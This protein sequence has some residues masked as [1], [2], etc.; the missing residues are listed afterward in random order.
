MHT[1][2]E[3][4]KT[5]ERQATVGILT[6]ER[7]DVWAEVRGKL[8]GADDGNRRALQL[9]EESMLVLILESG[10]RG[11][12]A[13]GDETTAA[14]DE[15]GTSRSQQT[16]LKA[17]VALMGDARNRWFDKSLQAGLTPNTAD[18][19]HPA[20]RAVPCGVQIGRLS[21]QKVKATAA[22]AGNRV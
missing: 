19:A 3:Q 13:T 17:R 7:R 5:G 8:A 1:R 21:G 6:S 22:R 14:R 10:P 20:T 16:T 2:V 11:R 4:M 18:S 15:H 9:I 12:A